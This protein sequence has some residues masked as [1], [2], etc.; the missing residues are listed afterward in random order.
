MFRVNNFKIT[1]MFNSIM[2]IAIIGGSSLKHYNNEKIIF[3]Q[4]HENNT[5]PH[6]INYEKLL[7]NLKDQGVT[8]IIGVSSVGSLK[9]NLSPG[10]IIIPSDY[11]NFNPITIFNNK[12]AHVV[13]SLDEGL[14]LNLIKTANA[15]KL[16]V[17]KKG[18]YF[19]TKGPRYETKAEINFIKN[20][21]DLVGMTMASEATIAKELGLKY[22][23]ICIVDNFANG[24]SNDALAHDEVLVSQ[25]KNQEKI[26]SLLDNLQGMEDF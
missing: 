15:L 18:V 22:A 19:Q 10:T 7:R 25:A 14:R 3:V 20:Y 26:I 1:L 17:E 24:I 5:P 12:L 6:M 11:I 23:S 13:P 8:H 16:V 4:R 9:E 21:A 2:K